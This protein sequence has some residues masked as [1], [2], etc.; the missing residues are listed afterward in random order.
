MGVEEC[1]DGAEEQEHILSLVEP[2]ALCGL[3][4]HTL[5]Q[6]AEGGRLRA[7]KVGGV[8]VATRECLEEYLAEHSWL[9]EPSPAGEQ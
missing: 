7:R 6:Q 2:A 5:A 8:W 9:R 1:P 3:S 4:A